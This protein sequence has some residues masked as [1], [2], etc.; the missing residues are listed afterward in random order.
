M[1]KKK[2]KR[3][4]KVH[5]LL[6]V[7]KNSFLQ[8]VFLMLLFQFMEAAHNLPYLNVVR[9]YQMY[10]VT[11]IAFLAWILFYKY[12]TNIA[13]LIGAIVAFVLA[14]P[15]IILHEDK[16]AEILGFI[17]FVLLCIVILQRIFRERTVLKDVSPDT[18][19]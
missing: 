1:E 10:E 19:E 14:V 11:I 5:H 15:M 6:E 7:I 16:V 4:D 8:I 3:F 13:L 17:A 9:N 18:N 12:I 2:V